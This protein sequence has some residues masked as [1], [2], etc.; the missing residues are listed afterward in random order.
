M[1]RWLLAELVGTP[2]TISLVPS[3]TERARRL[4]RQ[5]SA[6][7]L[8]YSDDV[9]RRWIE[10]SRHTQPAAGVFRQNDTWIAACALTFDLPQATLNVKHFLDFA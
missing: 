7:T 9:A 5:P 6:P 8:P 1:P 4:A 10:R 3:T 2:V